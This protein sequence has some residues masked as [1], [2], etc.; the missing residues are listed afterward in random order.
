MT[1]RGPIKGGPAATAQSQHDRQ[2]NFF[3]VAGEVGRKPPEQVTK[4]DAA[5]VQHFE[6]SYARDYLSP[7]LLTSSFAEKGGF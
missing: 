6:V 1:G 4:E 2:Q 3:A 5:K 7:S